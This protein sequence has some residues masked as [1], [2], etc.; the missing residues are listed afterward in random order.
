M[1]RVC[2]PAEPQGP[3]QRLPAEEA[4]RSA[5]RAGPAYAPHPKAIL[6]ACL[7]EYYLP[8]RLDT[9]FYYLPYKD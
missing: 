1:A 2:T 7:G 4:A 8:V 9:K 3:P 6:S 5:E